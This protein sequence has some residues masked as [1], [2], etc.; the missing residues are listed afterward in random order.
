MN[1]QTKKKRRQPSYFLFSHGSNVAGLKTVAVFDAKT[2]EF[3][4]HSPDLTVIR[5]KKKK[6]EGI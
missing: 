5:R 2:D 6:R 3:V 1:K 4:I